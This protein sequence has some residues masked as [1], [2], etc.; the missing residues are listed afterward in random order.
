MSNRKFEKLKAYSDNK[1]NHVVLSSADMEKF[2]IFSDM[3]LEKNKNVNLTA[4]ENQSDIEIKHF[5]D[6][7]T[8]TDLIKDRS[9]G[10]RFSLIDIGCGAGFPGIP[11]KIVFPEADFVLVDSVSKKTAFVEEAVKKLK[12]DKIVVENERA[13]VLAKTQY[14]ESFDFCTARAVSNIAVLL[15][16]MLPFLKIGGYCIL[17]KSG[18]YADELEAAKNALD[19][20]GGEIDTIDEFILPYSTAER[21]LIVIK[22]VG[23]T[24][25]KY[26]RKAGKP[27]KSPL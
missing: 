7:L 20:L 11:L 1:E 10:E 2:E 9:D 23:K 26:P 8:A 4:I 18:R 22:K 13:E 19:V 14:R 6:S 27:E 12:L 16:Y 21:S 3:L 25:D 15:E 17:Y 24:P 5:I